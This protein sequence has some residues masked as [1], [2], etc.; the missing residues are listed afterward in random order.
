MTILQAYKSIHSAWD[1]QE[2]SSDIYHMILDWIQM[3]RPEEVYPEIAEE[4][5]DWM[6]RALKNASTNDLVEDFIYGSTCN[7]IRATMDS[8]EKRSLIHNKVTH[9]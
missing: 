1:S 2:S 7:T 3:Y 9:V 6:R 8:H 4:V 5:Q